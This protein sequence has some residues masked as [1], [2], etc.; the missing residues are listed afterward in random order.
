ETTGPVPTRRLRWLGGRRWR[1][2]I[3]EVAGARVVSGGVF[4][5][6]LALVLAFSFGWVW[7]VGHRGLFM[8]DQS[9]V[10]DGAWRIVQGQ[11]PYRDFVMPFGPV[12]FALCALT[13]RVAGVDF[14]S[15]V[16]TAALMSSLA[17]AL[18]VRC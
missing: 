8:L 15:L 7:L 1:S 16:L 3:A 18:S 4:G 11:V 14:S 5:V 13:F 17:T 2:A 6:G 12:V 9:I 10:F